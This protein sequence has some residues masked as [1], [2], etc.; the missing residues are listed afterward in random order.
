MI[1]KVRNIH[2]IITAT[3]LVVM[4]FVS[5]FDH[6]D[7][8]DA[9]EL[10]P[11]AG[12]ARVQIAVAGADTPMQASRTF[13]PDMSEFDNISLQ[14]RLRITKNGATSPS[15]NLIINESDW[16]GYLEPG[17]YLIEITAL[18]PDIQ[19][20]VAYGSENFTVIQN[21]L[22]SV[23]VKLEAGQQGRGVFSYTINVPDNIT[24]S[25]G[26]IQF[27]SLSNGADPAPVF[28]TGNNLIGS[29]NLDSGFYRIYLCL[30]DTSEAQVKMYEITAVAHIADNLTTTA[31]YN[32][33]ID[34]F[35]Q[36]GDVVANSAGL[37]ARLADI[38]TR[39]V[40][41]YVITVSGVFQSARVI[42]SAGLENK[43]IILRGI[44]NAEIVG[45]GFEVGGATNPNGPNT[46]YH[47][48]VTLIL[49]N[50][51]IRGVNNNTAN[52]LVTVV[53]NSKLV[54]RDGARITGNSTGGVRV[55][56]GTLEITGGEISEN[57]GSG[58]HVNRSSSILMTNGAI[59]GNAITSNNGEVR[60]GGIHIESGSFE[61]TGG[62]IENN[63]ITGLTARGGGIFLMD[64][65]SFYFKGG[66]IRNNSC[67]ANNA[68]EGG[69]IYNIRTNNTGN[70]D[71]I[72]MSGGI[73]S[74]NKVI[75]SQLNSRGGG[76]F[77]RSRGRGFVKTGGI[78]YGNDVS[79]NDADGI[80][81]QNTHNSNS[82]NSGHAVYVE[83]TWF[84][85]RNSTAWANNNMDSNG[86]GW[87]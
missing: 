22:N 82:N 32:V 61:M 19:Q 29:I 48:N 87:E 14:Y 45:G 53:E 28:L 49:E 8:P 23:S 11:P 71:G 36:R 63:V 16:I 10:P 9:G 79:G 54:L 37:N 43:T 74:G 59:R 35:S 51:T 3:V 57:R 58:V 68:A 26:A 81:L 55:S 62:V 70:W 34:D 21:I 47:R 67:I 15:V 1:V 24:I 38:R 64:T 4:A 33:I 31:L 52:A 73:I 41:E 69:G 83:D 13:L 2:K 56:G 7:V 60:G 76:V 12:M 25:N 30:M 86:G 27:I 66:V 65:S 80:P 78:I 17:E 40:G 18:R 77:Q 20:A 46:V 39:P 6:L 5:C 50:I 75:S 42:L 44:G 85:F 84:M 72:I